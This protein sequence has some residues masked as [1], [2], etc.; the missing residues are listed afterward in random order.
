MLCGSAESD[1]FEKRFLQ[2][3]SDENDD[4]DRRKLKHN[5]EAKNANIE[6][7]EFQQSF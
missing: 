2:L 3:V 4:K 5:I 7:K 1:D 6:L